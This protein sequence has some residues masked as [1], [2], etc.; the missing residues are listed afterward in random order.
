MFREDWW[1][2][3][4]LRWYHRWSAVS[5][6]QNIVVTLF[7]PVSIVAGKALLIA[8][9]ELVPCLARSNLLAHLVFTI[10]ESR[11]TGQTEEKGE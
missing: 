4:L 8:A 2:P 5:A 6:G 9:I 10:R 1:L 7:P 11:A 3:V